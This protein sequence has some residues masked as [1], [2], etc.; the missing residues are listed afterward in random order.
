MTVPTE[1]TLPVP[2]CRKTGNSRDSPWI[3][4]I[5]YPSQHLTGGNSLK[6]YVYGWDRTNT[7]ERLSAPR[8]SLSDLRKIHLVARP[9]HRPSLDKR[10]EE[11]FASVTTA[12][13]EQ[14]MTA[15]TI[16]L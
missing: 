5:G 4:L 8:T 6:K 12:A 16:E 14:Q 13:E 15:L 11:T 3:V 2:T 7:L 10:R 1:V 9:R